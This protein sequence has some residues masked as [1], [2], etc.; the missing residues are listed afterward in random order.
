MKRKNFK[1]VDS[2]G[3][4]LNCYKWENDTC[5]IP[6]AIVQI[7]HGMSENILRYDE[8]ARELVEEGFTVYG[9]DHRGHGETAASIEDLGYMDDKDNFHSMVY[10]LKDMNDLIKRENEGI[11][12][13]LFGHSMGSFLSQRYIELYG[14]SIDGLIL[15]GS[16]GKQKA[17]NNLGI[18]ISYLEMK[19]F[20]R[21]KQSKLMDKLSF[22]S[23]NNNFKPVRTNCDW[24]TRDEK[25]V[26]KYL[27]NKYCGNIFTAS[28]FYDLLKGLKEI[29]KESNLK[30]IPK[31]L[32]IYILAGSKDPVGEN[33][34]GIINLYNLY[35]KLEIKNVSYKLY[36]G[37]RHEILNEI[38]RDEVINDIKNILEEILSKTIVYS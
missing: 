25:E 10:D 22:G 13:I 30:K 18:P 27:N 29:H 38:N 6:K 15:S 4:K 26:D 37:A 34:K 17:I 8:F 36:D 1:F 35:K 32:N 16:N 5:D 9:H 33:G 20:G 24:L 3:I 21:R 7:S 2:R 28:Y 12:I 19:I 14:D 11:P 23:F 31:S